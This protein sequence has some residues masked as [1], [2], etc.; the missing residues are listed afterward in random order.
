MEH[1]E[2]MRKGYAALIQ[3]Q[4]YFK[5][6]QD[7]AFAVKDAKAVTTSTRALGYTTQAVK[8]SETVIKRPENT[9]KA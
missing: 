9:T 1:I 3:A 2:T 4:T 8:S 7:Q 5:T 6:A